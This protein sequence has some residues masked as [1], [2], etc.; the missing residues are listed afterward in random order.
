METLHSVWL[1]L[2]SSFVLY[3]RVFLPGYLSMA[4]QRDP[5]L[6]EIF[7]LDNKL[8]ASNEGSRTVES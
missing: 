8:H 3:I 4:T 1:W 2:F 5:I 7:D 6:I